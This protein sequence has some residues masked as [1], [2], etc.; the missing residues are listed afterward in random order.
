MCKNINVNNFKVGINLKT[1]SFQCLKCGNCCKTKYLCLYP[2]ELGK[3]F[4]LADEVGINLEIQPLRF[5]IDFK[6][7]IILDLIYKVKTKP[8][9]FYINGTCEIHENRFIACRKYPFANWTRSPKL[10]VKLFKFPEFF[11]EIDEKCTFIQR[12]IIKRGISINQ[13]DFKE[14]FVYFKKDMEIF[15][16]IERL[17]EDLNKSNK[18]QLKKENKFK[19]NSPQKYEQI[20]ITWEHKAI[21]GY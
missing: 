16:R 12:K 20:I 14:D 17:L 8:C 9:P 1:I 3:A 10:F 2:H 15:L 6:N 19:R 21:T 11:H 5:R 13:I 18:I 7:E 4:E